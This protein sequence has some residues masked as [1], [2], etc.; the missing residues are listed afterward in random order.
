MK[1]LFSTRDLEIGGLL[2]CQVHDTA[3][4]LLEIRVDPRVRRIDE[5]HGRKPRDHHLAELQAIR[6]R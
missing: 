2:S 1:L 4:E 3:I 6:V 5:R